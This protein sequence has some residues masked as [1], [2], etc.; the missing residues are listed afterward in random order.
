MGKP[1]RYTCR[2][3]VKAHNYDASAPN[4]DPYRDKP[5]DLGEDVVTKEIWVSILPQ[6]GSEA[7][8]FHSRQ[9][10]MRCTIKT[11][12]LDGQG[13]TASH[14]FQY[15]ARRF[16]IQAVLPDDESRKDVT[17]LCEEKLTGV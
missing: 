8:D 15:G 7:T 10:I 3:Q 6:R 17:F 13:I 2:A 9:S 16:D 11:N 4:A 12:Y 1:I 14:Y 5:R